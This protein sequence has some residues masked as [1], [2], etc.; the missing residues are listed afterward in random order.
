MQLYSIIKAYIT[1]NK[2]LTSQR[3]LT[4]QPQRDHT[5]T[6]SSTAV[7]LRYSHTSPLCHSNRTASAC[8]RNARDRR[9][10]SRG[11]G[12]LAWEGS[13]RQGE[14]MHSL[15]YP[16]L[17]RALT[18]AMDPMGRSAGH[19]QAE[20]VHALH[21]T[22]KVDRASRAK[23]SAAQVQMVAPADPAGQRQQAP[24]MRGR[25]P[26]RSVSP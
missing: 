17:A 20:C 1:Y 12:Y 15:R 7:T 24:R 4:A 8:H 22:R 9:P 26:S 23:L 5:L 25:S 13:T 18:C 19:L 10:P 21:L 14:H 16:H 3:S 2:P 6:V 11:G